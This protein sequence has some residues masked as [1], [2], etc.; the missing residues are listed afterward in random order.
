MMRLIKHR[1]LSVCLTF[2]AGFHGLVWAEC[3]TSVPATTPDARFTIERASSTVKDLHTGLTWQRCA[4][5]EVWSGDTCTI[6][7][8]Q[9]GLFLWSE[10]L[11]AAQTQT[12]WR[13]PNKKELASIIEY[14][15]RLPA[16]NRALFPPAQ[17]ASEDQRYWSSTPL[18]YFSQPTVW[19]IDFA[20]GA[21]ANSA[22]DARLKV[23]LVKGSL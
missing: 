19:V 4:L 17:Q 15:C 23:R 9:A 12:G 5:G 1:F 20:D 3:D 10:A 21:F 22:A 6:D 2:I 13:L 14:Q 16:L 18:V 8:A 7:D 11:A